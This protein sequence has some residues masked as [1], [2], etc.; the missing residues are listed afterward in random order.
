MFHTDMAIDA[1]QNAKK[2]WLNTVVQNDE[3]KTPLAKFVDAQTAYTKQV[4]DSSMD[5]MNTVAKNMFN[6]MGGK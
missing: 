6:M 2:T 1:I 4:V 3:I 5:V